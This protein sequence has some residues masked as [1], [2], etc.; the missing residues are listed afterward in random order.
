MTSAQT[1]REHSESARRLA[2]RTAYE[3]DRLAFLSIARMWLKRAEH[4]DELDSKEKSQEQRK[5]D[6]V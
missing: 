5:P 4:L 6:Q 1:Y 2:G 3:E